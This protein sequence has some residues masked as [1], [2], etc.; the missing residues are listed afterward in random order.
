MRLARWALGL[1]VAVA[2]VAGVAV[3]L[4]VPYR[5]ASLPAGAAPLT[6]RTQPWKIWPSFGCAMAALTPIRVERDGVSMVF[7]DEAGGQP[8][9]GRLAERLLRPH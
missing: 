9:A 7:A 1:L 8:S 3:F 2:L 6:L 4:L 5:P